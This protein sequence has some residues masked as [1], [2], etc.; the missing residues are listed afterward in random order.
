MVKLTERQKK[1]IKELEPEL[2]ELGSILESVKHT[3]RLPQNKA[4]RMP[5]LVKDGVIKPI[6]KRYHPKL[7]S[8]SKDSFEDVRFQ[9]TDKG[10][11]MY[12]MLRGGM[13]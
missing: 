8:V 1:D 12:G 7:V 10:K 5:L 3:G 6:H 4:A 11:R 9:L 13:Y 2:R